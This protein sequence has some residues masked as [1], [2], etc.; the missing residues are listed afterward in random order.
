MHILEPY[1]QYVE[2][3]S[4]GLSSKPQESIDGYAIEAALNGEL[5]KTLRKLVP[6]PELQAAGAYFT[7]ESM[8]DQLVNYMPSEGLASRTILD[9]ACGGGNL[10]L[11]HA[12]RL[13]VK[14]N[15]FDTLSYWGGLIQGI[16]LHNE[17]VRATRSR[18]ALL[19]ALRGI[20]LHGHSFFDGKQIDIK[21][22]FPKISCGDSLD[23]NWPDSD[24]LLL[25]PPFNLVY[26]PNDC[27]WASGRVSQAALFIIKA[28]TTARKGTIIRAILP[29][30]LRSGSRYRKWRVLVERLATVESIE[31]L[32]QFDKQ[33][34]VDVFILTLFITAPNNFKRVNWVQN[35]VIDVKEAISTV[36]D[37][38]KITV[39]KVVPHRDKEEGQEY[40]YLDVKHLPKWTT[41]HPGEIRRRFS[42]EVFETP[43]VIVRRN[44]RS[45]DSHR[46]VATLVVSGDPLNNELVAVENHLFVIK[47]N[48]STLE[49][50]QELMRVLH[51]ERTNTWLNERIR[52]RHLNKI[53]I[54]SIPWWQ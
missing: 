30:I 54:H 2:S 28:I 7:G 9:S 45:K 21:Q 3:L 39:G 36:G 38:C 26:V 10:L 47:P 31:I 42:G 23:I 14:S 19:A 46:A 15:F 52:C 4:I 44:S 49:D 34:N 41:L 13:E 32:G 29:D 43:F 48:T 53:S 37:L 20:A 16:D 27:S 50:C 51:E 25:N 18:L 6:N 35:R 33:T 22:L 11:A 12:R 5:S 8:A 40:A 24:L 1:I 17:F